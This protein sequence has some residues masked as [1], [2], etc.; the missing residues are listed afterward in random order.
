MK[1][2]VLPIPALRDNYIWCLH[3]GRLAAIVD[4]GDP[5]PV[6]AWLER[7]G[8][9]L[10]AILITHHHA[11]HVAGVNSLVAAH[12]CLVYGPSD[13]RIREVT[14]TVSDG[15]IIDLPVSQLRLQ[16]LSVPGHTLGHVAYYGHRHLFS[17]DT[18]FSCGCGRLFEG[19][20]LQMYRSLLRLARLPTNTL[21]CCAHEYTLDNIAFARHVD[22]ENEELL[23]WEEEATRLH[24]AGLPTLPVE[25]SRE[26]LINPFLRCHV[27][28]IKAAAEEWS[29][30]PLKQPH[31][32][33]A[34][35]RR[36]K[37]LAL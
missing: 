6:E 12:G 20:P 27:P 17:G 2:E 9:R 15:D 21:I 24:N 18:L 14:Q 13:A 28:R 22:T 29:G 26:L 36:M 34:V 31:E 25:L 1:I 19:T 33:F 32:V 23:A 3:D 35:L 16:A 7:R 30:M 8:L 4:P 5:A 37:D 11:D 10:A